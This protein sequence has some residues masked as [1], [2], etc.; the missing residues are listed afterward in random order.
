MKFGLWKI[1]AID[2][3][4]MRDKGHEKWRGEGHFKQKKMKIQVNV[5][6][7]ARGLCEYFER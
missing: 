1:S 4:S 3:M 5:S 6:F 2:Q 7:A